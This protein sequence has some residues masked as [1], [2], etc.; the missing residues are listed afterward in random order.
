MGKRTET[1]QPGVLR[2][3][4]ALRASSNPAFLPL[5]FDEHRYLVLCGGGGSGKSIFAGRKVLERLTSEKGHRWL[6]CRKV[7]RTLRESCFAQLRGQIAAHYPKAGAKISVSDMRISFPNGSEILFAGLDDVEKLKSIYDITGIWVEE[8]SE[9]TEADFNQLDIRLRTRFPHYL[10]IILSFNP[11]SITHW[12]KRRFFDTPDPRATTH[13]STYKD[14]RFLTAEAVRTLEAFKD[15]DPY[16]YQV[17]CLGEWGVTGKTV[18]DGQA[19]SERLGSLPEP[20][21]RGCWEYGDDMSEIRWQD[22]SDPVTI[23]REPEEGKPYVIGGDTS[24]EGSD[25]FV[26]QVLDN[27]TGEQVAILR[28]QYDEDTYADETAYDRAWNEEDRDYDRRYRQE[29]DEVLDRRADR[30]WAQ[31]LRA[32][33]DQQDWKETEWQQYLREYGDQLSDQER[34]W[35]YEMARDAASDRR[36]ADETA[37]QRALREE[38]TAYERK[39]DAAGDRRYDT[40]WQQSLR[41]YEDEQRQQDFDNAL[42]RLQALGY[43]RAEDAAILG[44][45]AGT[46]LGDYNAGS[47]SSRPSAGKTKAAASGKDAADSGRLTYAGTHPD[48]RKRTTG[49]GELKT[50][51]RNTIVGGMGDREQLRRMIGQWAAQGRI[52]DYEVD[53]LW[54]EFG[55]DSPEGTARGGASGGRALQYTK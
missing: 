41:E 38:E 5:F 55:L 26:A 23:Y 28:H 32:Y 33:A 46:A 22:G 11:I 47:G 36:Y 29:R 4:D 12:L 51:L 7:A 16:Y 37:W 34:R 35:A 6:V 45:P 21:K 19:V 27:T 39:R 53:I 31:D 18:F 48:G 30:Q 25:F 10:Q 2:W 20:V 8:A 49:Y 42:K 13:R 3:Y 15:T 44:V 40:Q 17:Y 24:G 54:K 50:L 52:E 1:R 9:I 43:V 14:N